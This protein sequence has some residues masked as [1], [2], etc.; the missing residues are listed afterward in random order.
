MTQEELEELW[1]DPGHWRAVFIYDCLEDPRL[2]VSKR[3]HWTG[4]TINFAHPMAI[5]VLIGMLLAV[6]APFLL[7]VLLEP[8][9]SV[10]GVAVA[11]VAVVSVLVALCHWE[12]TRAR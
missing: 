6:L 8:P 5:P 4:Y 2:I 12:S 10:I 1:R 7:L 9:Q 3:I 11:F